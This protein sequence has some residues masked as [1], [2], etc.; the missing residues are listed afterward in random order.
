M[1]KRQKQAGFTIVELLIVIVVIGILAAITIVAFNGVTTK[2]ENTKTV[3]A[4][5]AYS[6]AI[7]GYAAVNSAY[8]N[9]AY[10]CLGPSGTNCGNVTDNTGAC[11]FI[12]GTNYSGSFDTAIKTIASALPGASTQSMNCGGKSYGGA[13]YGSTDGKAA[14]ITY[15]LKGNVPCPSVSGLSSAGDYRNGDTTVCYNNLP[16]L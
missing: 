16:T 9:F 11:N 12:G 5:A 1:F 6:K 2:A 10:P 3:N 14:T 7:A 8:P 4:V 15:F 13:F